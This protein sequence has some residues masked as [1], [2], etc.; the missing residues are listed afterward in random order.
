MVKWH[1]LPWAMGWYTTKTCQALLE[2]YFY[3]INW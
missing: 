1:I 2:H 3:S